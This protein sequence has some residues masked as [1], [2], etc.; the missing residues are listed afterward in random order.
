LHLKLPIHLLKLHQRLEAALL[1]D[2]I[3]EV[4]IL[5]GHVS[6][7]LPGQLLLGSEAG[8]EITDGIFEV[9]EHG[10]E[11]FKFLGH[12]KELIRF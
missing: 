9:T 12:C 3:S 5:G 2:H 8:L 6:E 10:F 4:L 11:C 1:T 7:S